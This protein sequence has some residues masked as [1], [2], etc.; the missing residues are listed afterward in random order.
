MLF[1]PDLELSTPLLFFRV[2]GFVP[3]IDRTFYQK[4]NLKNHYSPFIFFYKMEVGLKGHQKGSESFQINSG[5]SC[6]IKL[7]YS[8]F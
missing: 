8:I 2:L 4:Y 1:S 3:H 6:D 7:N 5:D